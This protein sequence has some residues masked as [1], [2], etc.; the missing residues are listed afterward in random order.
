MSTVQYSKE[1]EKSIIVPSTV[2]YSGGVHESD[3]FTSTGIIP[4]VAQ[5]FAQSDGTLLALPTHQPTLSLCVPR[6]RATKWKII[7]IMHSRVG[8]S[9]I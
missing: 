4:F 8:Y 1:R 2:Q 3:L 6:N 7:S 9:T 5:F